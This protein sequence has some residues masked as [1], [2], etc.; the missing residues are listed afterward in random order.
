MATSGSADLTMTSRE[1]VTQAMVLLQQI[2]YGET[3]AA[4]DAEQYRIS[5]NLMIKTW[6]AAGRLWLTEEGSIPLVASTASY[7]LTG[8][9][10]VFQVRRRI[11]STVS[12]LELREDSRSDY[13]ARPNKASTGAPLA[14][15]F[16]PQRTTKT[17]YVWP[18]PD[19]TA[20]STM[21]LQYTY[22][23]FIEDVDALD[24][25]ADVPQEWLEA[26]V[27]GLARRMGPA[28]GSA[29]KPEYA[30]IK[31]DAERLYAALSSVDQEEASIMLQPNL[32]GGA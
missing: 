4:E 16:D 29:N 23:R 22:A 26:L 7:A 20:A 14:W 18:A 5:L 25:E 10:K 27:Y 9:R 1:I 28:T 8:V 15:Y 31:E 30:Q 13:Y 21:T 11:T 19:T 17:L 12:D 6:G 3:P 32:M 24:D 2:S